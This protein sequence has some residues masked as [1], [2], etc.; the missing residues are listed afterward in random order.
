MSDF[1]IGEI[2][3]VGLNFAPQGWAFCDGQRLP[4]SQYSALFSLIGTTYGG[5]GFTNFALPN[6]TNRVPIGIGDGFPLGESG[7]EDTHELTIAEMPEHSHPLT[8]STA[9]GRSQTPSGA[10]PATVSRRTA[11]AEGAPSALLAAG[12]IGPAGGDLPHENRA[13]FL[14]V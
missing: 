4:I 13:P 3:M 12:S 5:D 6:L 14:N 11:Y 8:G 1:Y 7:G 10:V 2:R 9:T